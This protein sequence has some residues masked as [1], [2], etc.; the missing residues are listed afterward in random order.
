MSLA[1]PCY[2]TEPAASFPVI[3]LARPLAGLEWIGAL[4]VEPIG[5]E[6]SGFVTLTALEDPEV[7][8]VAVNPELVCPGYEA[9]IDAGDA[10]LLEATAPEDLIVFALCSA[11]D[12][13]APATANLLA[14]IVVNWRTLRCAQVVLHGSAYPVRAPMPY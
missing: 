10:T 4:T 3:T 2:P 9:T 6:A 11:R 8:F 5:D 13:L 1:E 7:A 14:P 12:E